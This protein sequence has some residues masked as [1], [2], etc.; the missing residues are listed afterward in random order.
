MEDGKGEAIGSYP[1]EGLI[2]K[3]RAMVLFCAG[4]GGVASVEGL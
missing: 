2:G 1:I 3:N 4:A